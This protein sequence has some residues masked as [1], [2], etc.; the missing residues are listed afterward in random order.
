V[1][2]RGRPPNLNKTE[3]IETN[4]QLS[5][6]PESSKQSVEDGSQSTKTPSNHHQPAAIES[7]P[8]PNSTHRWHEPLAQHP[9]TF[10]VHIAIT[11]IY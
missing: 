5:N 1:S 8:R 7:D 2:R 10:I 3:A 6:E 9:E 4:N 11:R